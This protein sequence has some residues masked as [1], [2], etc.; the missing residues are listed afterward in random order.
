M[1]YCSARGLCLVL[2]VSI[3]TALHAPANDKMVFPVVDPP[4]EGPN[5]TALAPGASTPPDTNGAV[6]PNHLLLATNG[7]V[8]IHD[9]TGTLLSSV[10]LAAFW[11]GLGVS[12]I[13]DPRSI[14]DPHNQRFIM[15]TCAQRRNA[16]SSMLFAVSATDDPTGTWHQ[17]Q[18]DADAA[19]T[20]WVDYGNLGF[21]AN[22]IT[23]SGNMFTIAGDAFTGSTFWR[24]NTASALDGGALTMEQFFSG[25]VGGTVVP[26]ATYDASETIQYMVRV[27]TAN[28]FGVG[29]VNVMRLGGSIGTSSIVSSPSSALGDAWSISL[30]DA[31]QLGSASLIETNDN[32]ILS[33]VYQNGSLW[34][35]HTVAL[36]AMAPSHTAAKWWEINPVTGD[37]IQSGVL[38]DPSGQQFYYFPALTVNE[39]GVM[40]LG[41]SGSA[42]TEYVSTY[43][44]WRNPGVPNGLLTGVQQY[45]A[46]VGPYSGPRWGDY[47]GVYL[48]P[49]D[50]ES[51]WVLQQYAETSNQWGIQWVKL[52][53]NVIVGLSA[54][55]NPVLVVTLLFMAILGAALLRNRF[56]SGPAGTR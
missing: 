13:F 51:I 4:I 2:I 33:A 15:I 42:S 48:D 41:C 8:R 34:A 11:S 7:T 32:R 3:L 26:V 30:P 44:A 22:E 55:G 53:F 19:N 23:F 10:S 29:R 56:R 43:Y 46:G 24:I 21:T 52:T 14:F 36:P 12:D 20:D 9:R 16:A 25:G 37:A 49:V 27:G 47:S 50:G 54:N 17:W 5:F 40:G 1:S 28:I 39:T 18:L 31:P 35:C 6:G 45:H 38:E